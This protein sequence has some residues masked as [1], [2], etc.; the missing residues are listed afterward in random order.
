MNHAQRLHVADGHVAA[1]ETR[2]AEAILDL[3]PPS[4]VAER[5]RELIKI[6]R[7]R[8]IPDRARSIARRMPENYGD[9]FSLN[10]RDHKHTVIIF[11]DLFGKFWLTPPVL[12]AW[13]HPFKCRIVFLRCSWNTMFLSADNDIL[14]WSQSL[15]HSVEAIAGEDQRALKIM[16]FSNG[17]FASFAAASRISASRHLGFSIRSNLDPESPHRHDGP[18]MEDFRPMLRELGLH[19]D[20]D[21][22]ALVAKHGNL[23]R[24]RIVAPMHNPIDQ[25]HAANV[26]GVPG[27]EVDWLDTPT[28]NTVKESILLGKFEG[29]LQELLS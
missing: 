28:H 21:I 4:R 11:T 20:W 7:S 14:S 12:A 19:A 29:Y 25:D 1:G 16:G 9:S 3:L 2:K 17:G 26:M 10:P 23:T 27:I 5:L 24:S 13:L 15:Q 8:D 6:F 22:R 18:Y